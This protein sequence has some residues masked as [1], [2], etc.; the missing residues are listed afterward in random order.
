[1]H[2]KTDIVVVGA[3][4]SGSFSALTAAKMGA[5]VT[6]CEEHKEIGL[7]SHCAGHISIK[8]LMHLGLHLPTSAVEN[9]IKGAVFYSPSGREFR[10]RLASP[11]TYVI[12]RA[13]FDKQLA[14]FAQKAG[15]KFL[16]ETRVKS[17]LLGNGQVKGVTFGNR[18]KI[19]SKLVI[20]A[21][22]CA[23]T[24]LKQIGL[25]MFDRSLVVNAVNGE[26]SQ[27]DGVEN[28]TVEVYLGQ[29]FAPGLFAW[30]IPRRDGS[31]KVGLA[32]SGNPRKCLKHF[33]K[34]HPIARQKF[35]SN[36]VKN[37]AYHLI[38]LGGPIPKTYYDGFVTVGDA[39]SQVKP[40]TG[41]GVIMGLTCAKIAGESAYHA[42]QEN[43]FSETCLSR[44]QHMWQKKV[45][46]DMMV[47]RRIRL[48]LN[49]LSD[50]RLD[51]II[52]L[53]SR[54]NLSES[55]QEIPE[56]DFQGK[57]LIDL[58]KSPAAWVVALYSLFGYLTSGK[59]SSLDTNL[60]HN[61]S[62]TIAVLSRCLN[63]SINK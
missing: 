20:D 37:L 5:E 14:Q 57:T 62:N 39:A 19:A 56:I 9:Q 46:F 60:N 48:M 44:Y 50:R 59:V 35:T 53:S 26:V 3:G 40:T 23:S 25:Q 29:K 33:L 15:V 4:P 51:K 21:E 30:I 1:M 55:L 54:L 45:G 22:G 6:V 13:M 34:S 24:I 43:D 10:V 36:G 28:D 42:I 63:S 32:T 12:E 17:L 58:L 11:V 18:E 52:H 2:R 16:L 61:S 38:P 41:G 31:A 47:M 49:R 8:G 7:P 27:I